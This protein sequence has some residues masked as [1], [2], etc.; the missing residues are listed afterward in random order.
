MTFHSPY[1]RTESA[2]EPTLGERLQNLKQ[3]MTP[4]FKNIPDDHD[5]ATFFC[6]FDG[7]RLTWHEDEFYCHTHGKYDIRVGGRPPTLHMRSVLR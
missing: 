7:L 2:S 3:T 4:Q 6:P 1:G 5:G